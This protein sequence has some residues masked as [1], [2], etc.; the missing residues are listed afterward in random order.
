MC[1]KHG[2]TPHLI[3]FESLHLHI[4]TGLIEAVDGQE[5]SGR[6]RTRTKAKQNVMM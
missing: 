3:I 6:Q 4:L 2:G 5:L 1:M